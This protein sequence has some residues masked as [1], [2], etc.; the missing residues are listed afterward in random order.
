M[1]LEIDTAKDSPEEIQAA[2]HMLQAHIRNKGVYTE[3][4]RYQQTERVS[5]EDKL[6]RKIE[7]AKEKK[8]SYQQSNVTETAVSMNMFDTPTNSPKEYTENNEV[9]EETDVRIIPY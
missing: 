1:K 8:E 6:A 4:R 2:I 9:P 3:P 7:R 5:Y